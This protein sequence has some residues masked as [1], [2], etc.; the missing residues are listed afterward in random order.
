MCVFVCMF[1]SVHA[2]LVPSSRQKIR[3]KRSGFPGRG[4]DVVVVLAVQTHIIYCIFAFAV[5][6]EPADPNPK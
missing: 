3:K 2:Y 1:V 6:V 4:V 5:T